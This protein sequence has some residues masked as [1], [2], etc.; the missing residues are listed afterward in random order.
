MYAQFMVPR[1]AELS[2]RS[3]QLHHPRWGGA[4]GRYRT[5]H[6][7]CRGSLLAALHGGRQFV[8]HTW[9]DLQDPSSRA[10]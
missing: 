3:K 7:R 10:R 9:C 5:S 4:T 2:A 8:T 6:S 1:S